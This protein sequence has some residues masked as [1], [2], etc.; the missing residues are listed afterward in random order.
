MPSPPSVLAMSVAAGC[1]GPL[2]GALS[3]QGAAAP[4]APGSLASLVAAERAFAAQAGREGMRAA[5]LH[6]FADSV[7]TFSPLPARGTR[8]LE[9][10]PPGPHLEWWPAVA[11]IS[12]DGTLGYTT[13][14]YRVP[15]PEGGSGAWGH[16]HSVWGVRP[17]GSW[18]VLLDVGGPHGAVPIPGSVHTPSGPRVRASPSVGAGGAPDVS[19]VERD[20]A[21][22][23]AYRN[24]GREATRRFG[25][26]RARVYR[27][28]AVPVDG[29]AAALAEQERRAERL[30]WE[31]LGGGMAGSADLG[32]TWGQGTLSRSEGGEATRPVGYARIWRRHPDGSWRFVVEVV[33]AEG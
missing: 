5:F 21:Y 31:V 15:A 30:E 23:R 9:E 18:R 20:G 25:S 8:A 12:A 19:P 1:L 28:G 32:Y 29:L 22:L 6:W 4:A 10:G 26:R 14:P 17:D 2:P 24:E 27:P 16:Y 13:G 7:V 33:L 11:E 3:A